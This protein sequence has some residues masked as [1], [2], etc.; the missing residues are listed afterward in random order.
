MNKLVFLRYKEDLKGYKL[1]D[2]KNKELVSSRHVTLDEA[3]IVKPTISQKVETMKSK[4]EVSQRVK[5][6]ATQHYPVGSVS[7]GILSVVTP[8][9]DRVA[10]M[11]TEHVE[12]DGSKAAR[13]TK[14]NPLR[15]VEK[16]RVSYIDEVHM[17]R[18]VGFVAAKKR[19]G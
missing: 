9:G 10:D 13:E 18:P 2:P 5:I 16:K 15:W 19:V 11:E 17:T 6:D 3:S 14:R 7:S 8:S 12:K 4:S 1:W